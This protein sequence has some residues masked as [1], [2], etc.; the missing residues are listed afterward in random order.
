MMNT[1][2]IDWT[3]PVE[4]TDGMLMT[5]FPDRNT[6]QPGYPHW[7]EGP[8]GTC[9]S[10]FYSDSGKPRASYKPDLRNVATPAETPTPDIAGEMEA[11]TRR[12]AAGFH[13]PHINDDGIT[14]YEAVAAAQAIVRSLPPL[15]DPD[16]QVARDIWADAADDASEDYRQ[17]IREG[18]Y[19]TDRTFRA[20]LAALKRGKQ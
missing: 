1:Q 7:V 5:Y 19:D 4:T 13:L 8:E 17:F 2:K 20:V 3:Q 6:C 18:A 11:L 10:S 12:L 14:P 16:I 9:I 15:P